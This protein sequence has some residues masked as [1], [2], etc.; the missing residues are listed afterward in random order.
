MSGKKGFTLI[1]IM[2]TIAVA[3]VLLAAGVPSLNS[4]Y[5]TTRAEQAVK[6]IQSTI[7]FARNQAMSY[8]LIVSLCPASKK[9]CG[10]K[11]QAGMQV[12]VQR[13][14]GGKADAGKSSQKNKKVVLRNIGAFNSKDQIKLKYNQ[15]QFYPDGR[16]AFLSKGVA[17][18]ETSRTRL[19]YC[20]SNRANENSQAV[21]IHSGGS[22]NI[23]ESG[24]NCK[25]GA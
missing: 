24:V 3:S 13:R 22:T 19:V 17:D 6:Q 11:W 21:E 15:L 16:V 10:K 14:S 9:G 1:E 8:N 2:V 5:E 12:F 7:D 23:I 20:P 18:N 25:S 4:L